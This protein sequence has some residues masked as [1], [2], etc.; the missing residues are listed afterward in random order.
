MFGK[1]GAQKPEFSFFTKGADRE[2]FE[3][4]ESSSRCA[5]FVN[6][7]ENASKIV[8]TRGKWV[9]DPPPKS[10]ET[11]GKSVIY[12]DPKIRSPRY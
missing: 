1:C 11:R 4:P 8:E 10:T 2:A 12:V 5:P 7:H 6:E 9:R 3:R